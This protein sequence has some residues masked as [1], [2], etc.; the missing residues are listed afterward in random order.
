MQGKGGLKINSLG[1]CDKCKH[2]KLPNKK[3]KLIFFILRSFQG[4]RNRTFDLKVIK[5]GAEKQKNIHI[6]RRTRAISSRKF[7]IDEIFPLK[8]LA[9]TENH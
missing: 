2:G 6:D 1:N 7:I 3:L 9:G 4:L 5:R 8:Y